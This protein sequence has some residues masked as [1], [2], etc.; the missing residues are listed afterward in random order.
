MRK[1]G[2]GLYKN[3]VIESGNWLFQ[4]DMRSVYGYKI[5]SKGKAEVAAEAD[6]FKLIY[7][8]YGDNI[9]I[10]ILYLI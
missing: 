1:V 10:I 6:E 5:D 7:R 3:L 9:D 4:K 2:I 8:L